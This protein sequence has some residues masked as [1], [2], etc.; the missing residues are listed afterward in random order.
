MTFDDCQKKEEK[1][2]TFDLYKII[3]SP[4]KLTPHGLVHK[5]K[6]ICKI[7]SLKNLYFKLL[8]TIINFASIP[9]NIILNVLID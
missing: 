1:V 9:L 7:L 5:Y 6:P 3:L 8:C 4:P 2:M